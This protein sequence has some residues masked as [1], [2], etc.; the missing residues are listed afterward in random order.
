[1]DN[2]HWRE[3]YDKFEEKGLVLLDDHYES[4]LT[5][6]N[7]Q[8]MCGEE[9]VMTYKDLLNNVEK[10]RTCI[11]SEFEVKEFIR[12]FKVSSSDKNDPIYGLTL[13]FAT[14]EI[15]VVLQFFECPLPEEQNLYPE[16]I[17]QESIKPTLYF[18]KWPKRI[19]NS[20][21]IIYRCNCGFLHCVTWR[22]LRCGIR[23]VNCLEATIRETYKVGILRHK[24]NIMEDIDEH[25]RDVNEMID[26]ISQKINPSK[27]EKLQIVNDIFED[28][29][30]MSILEMIETFGGP[31]VTELEHIIFHFHHKYNKKYSSILFSKIE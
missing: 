8:C 18:Y 13:I 6:M 23:C 27:K 22:G 24:M 26:N 15:N 25:L 29:I 9:G 30:I 3:I 12:I 10:C 4:L 11:R 31:A 1:M 7:F 5:P 2:L 20:T 14:D 21:Y 17:L 19:K 28:D 16:G